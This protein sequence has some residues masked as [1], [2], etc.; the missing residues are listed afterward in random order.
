[1]CIFFSTSRWVDG[2]AGARPLAAAKGTAAAR[3]SSKERREQCVDRNGYCRFV[4][5]SKARPGPN[6][7]ISEKK[8]RRRSR[9]PR[10]GRPSPTPRNPQPQP[11][12]ARAAGAPTS[13]EGEPGPRTRA[14][15]RRPW[16][17]TPEHGKETQ[18]IHVQVP[19]CHL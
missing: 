10:R 9:S 15:P 7:A 4:G 17:I 5:T 6:A 3:R 1:M 14:P 8:R 18:N 2:D 16:P 11:P 19:A 13:Q 12:K